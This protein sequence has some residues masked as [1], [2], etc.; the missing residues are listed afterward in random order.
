MRVSHRHTALN[1]VVMDE[2]P[3]GEMIFLL[4]EY[5]KPFGIK[6]ISNKI[7]DW[8]REAGIPHCSAHGFRKAAVP[9]A[10]E[11][12]ATGEQLRM[13]FAWKDAKE[14]ETYTRAAPT[15][16]HWE[17]NAL[18]GSGG[19]IGTKILPEEL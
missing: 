8:T 17:I 14:A 19:R 9:V 12:G 11:N 16:G 6:G 3:M 13:I 18:V 4:T 15:K 1:M 2:A 10:A 7:K 5:G